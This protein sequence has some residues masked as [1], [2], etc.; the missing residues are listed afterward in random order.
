MQFLSNPN[1]NIYY[2][3]NSKIL[4]SLCVAIATISPCNEQVCIKIFLQIQRNLLSVFNFCWFSAL[5]QNQFLQLRFLYFKKFHWTLFAQDFDQ[6]VGIIAQIQ[7]SKYTGSSYKAS[8]YYSNYWYFIHKATLALWP[9]D[10]T[11]TIA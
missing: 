4:F 7:L 1:R 2:P 6:L 9:S 8:T 11:F 3:D 5:N 10:D